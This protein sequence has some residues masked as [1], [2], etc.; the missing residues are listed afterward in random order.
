MEFQS[1]RALHKI[2]P[3]GKKE[4]VREIHKSFELFGDINFQR[5]Q[6]KINFMHCKLNRDIG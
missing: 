5:E 1:L 3:Q 6:I 4:S 2:E